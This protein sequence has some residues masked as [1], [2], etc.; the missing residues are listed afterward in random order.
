VATQLFNDSQAKQF[1]FRGMVQNVQPDQRGVQL[2]IIL[3]LASLL[4][5]GVVS[6]SDIGF[7]KFTSRSHLFGSIEDQQ[8]KSTPQP[9]N[10]QGCNRRE[11]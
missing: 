9:M 1:P 10:L 3:R 6:E 11:T 7:R 4:G 2:R 8:K 5:H